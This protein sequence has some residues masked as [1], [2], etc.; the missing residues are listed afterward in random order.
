MLP[1]SMTG[2]VCRSSNNDIQQALD[3]L[4]DEDMRA[5]LEAAAVTRPE[6]AGEEATASRARKQAEQAKAAPQDV[7]SPDEHVTAKGFDQKHAC[8][9]CLCL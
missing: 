9:T 3:L 2:T 8:R 5:S 4:S 1:S 7:R 6:R